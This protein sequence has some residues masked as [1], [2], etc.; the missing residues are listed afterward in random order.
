M[1]ENCTYCSLSRLEAF[2]LPIVVRNEQTCRSLTQNMRYYRQYVLT[3]TLSTNNLHIHKASTV[4]L[5]LDYDLKVAK[6][7]TVK[8]KRRVN[9]FHNVLQPHPLSPYRASASGMRCK[10][11]Y[12][13]PFL[14]ILLLLFDNVESTGKCKI[15]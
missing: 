9:A 7:L 13:Y 2:A 12:F 6:F 10:F 4:C 14:Q 15:N 8:K 5:S 11:I 1:R 3:H